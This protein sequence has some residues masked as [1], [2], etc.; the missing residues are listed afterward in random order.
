MVSFRA[1]SVHMKRI[2][3]YNR[4]K[5]MTVV[6]NRNTS[7]PQ[8]LACN[9]HVLLMPSFFFVGNRHFIDTIFLLWSLLAGC[10]DGGWALLRGLILL[11]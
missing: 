1:G 6:T 3:M 2:L 5:I 8:Q 4:K 11:K 9:L 10:G 7:N